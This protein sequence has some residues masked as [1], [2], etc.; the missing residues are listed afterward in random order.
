MK[1]FKGIN[2]IRFLLRFSF[3]RVFNGFMV[4]F[5]IKVKLLWFRE[6]NFKFV[7]LENVF[8]LRELILLKLRFS[9]W[10]D[11]S[12]LKWFGKIVFNLFLDKLR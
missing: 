3:L 6:R 8:F 12:L 9:V 11:E 1:I 10:S 2:V 5:G 4:F 7:Y